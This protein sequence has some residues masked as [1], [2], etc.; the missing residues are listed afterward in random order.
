MGYSKTHSPIIRKMLIRR[1][2]WLRKLHRKMYIYLYKNSHPLKIVYLLIRMQWDFCP[3]QVYQNKVGMIQ[4]F[5]QV[6]EIVGVISH[7]SQI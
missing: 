3:D 7:I 2:K 4:C 6:S 1:N 5:I